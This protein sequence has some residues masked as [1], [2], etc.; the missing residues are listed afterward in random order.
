MG[1]NT[2]F[3]LLEGTAHAFYPACT[4]QGCTNCW[5]L[6][7]LDP[8]TLQHTDVV[9]QNALQSCVV[10]GI[11]AFLLLVDCGKQPVPV[12]TYSFVAD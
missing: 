4:L 5:M 12:L 11:A 9:K 8:A 7:V 1:A 6:T 3:V 10:C 2:G